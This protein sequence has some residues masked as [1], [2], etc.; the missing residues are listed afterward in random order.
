MDNMF[1][2]SNIMSKY[3]GF[4]WYAPGH[5]TLRQANEKMLYL[6]NNWDKKDSGNFQ[7]GEVTYVVNPIYADK[8]FVAPF[9]TGKYAG[10]QC[11]IV[12]V[13]FRES[14]RVDRGY[15]C[16]LRDD[17]PTARPESVAWRTSWWHIQ[18]DHRFGRVGPAYTKHCR[19]ASG[20]L[21]RNTRCG[22]RCLL[23]CA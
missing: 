14:A 15:G 6:A 7:Y 1:G 2:E 12:D 20:L 18:F 9:D 13:C 17:R 23:Q 21:R 4:P 8:F 5:I 11:H 10:S 16:W 22:R 19:C 3:L